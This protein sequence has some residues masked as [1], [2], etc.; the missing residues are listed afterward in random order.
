MGENLGTKRSS[1]SVE[2]QETK[3]GSQDL[4][5]ELMFFASSWNHFLVFLPFLG[6]FIKWHSGRKEEG[7]YGKEV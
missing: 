2:P 3:G 5:T 6:D 4:H 1:N 7:K